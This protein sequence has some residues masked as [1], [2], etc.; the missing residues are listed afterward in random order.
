MEPGSR[1]VF[2]TGKN[3]GHL[4]INWRG[5]KTMKNGYVRLLID[6][7]HP[8]ANGQ[9]TYA[10][11]HRLVMAEA[12]G[13]PL[14]QWETVHHINGDRTDNRLENLQLHQGEHG[15]GVVY[16]CCDCGSH[17]VM[18]APLVESVSGGGH[19]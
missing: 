10:S 12:I 6:E 19:H 14:H 7:R 8:L 15:A 13:R 2:V 1:R 17:N 18:P 16:R 5:G 11:A 4:N 9:R 3:M